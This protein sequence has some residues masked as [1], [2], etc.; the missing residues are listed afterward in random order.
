MYYFPH[1]G[2]GR[3]SMSIY[4]VHYLTV[5]YSPSVTNLLVV[6]RSWRKTR[7]GWS[8]QPCAGLLGVYDA[9]ELSSPFSESRSCQASN[10]FHTCPHPRPHHMHQW[11]VLF[12]ATKQ[13]KSNE[14]WHSS[15][16]AAEFK[17]RF[18]HITSLCFD[19]W[20]TKMF[21]IQWQ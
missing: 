13:K 8:W 9:A 15:I 16:S 17:Q 3:V 5:I 11:C 2:I 12:T 6:R 14:K 4:V 21:G 18:T 19:V 10:R 20:R 7:S 1:G